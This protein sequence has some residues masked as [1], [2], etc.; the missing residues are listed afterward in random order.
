MNA[1]REHAAS[2]VPA[3][4]I[5]MSSS[6]TCIQFPVHCSYPYNLQL[7]SSTSMRVHCN[8]TAQTGVQIVIVM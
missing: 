8:G 3:N 7:S 6:I 4:Q 1:R 5:R 2:G